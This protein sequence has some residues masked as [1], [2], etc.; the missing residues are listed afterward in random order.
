MD[1]VATSSKHAAK[2][3]GL[4]A[5]LT[6]RLVTARPRVRRRGA[7]LAVVEAVVI[8]LVPPRTAGVGATLRA[9]DA[10]RLVVLVLVPAPTELGETKTV[11]DDFCGVGTLVAS[12]SSTQQRISMHREEV[13]S[14]REAI[15]ARIAQHAA[16][17]AGR[18]AV[19][20]RARRAGLRVH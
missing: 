9:V 8:L 15:R 12:S 3:D 17:F 7:D 18:L 14:A 13:S 10:G 11:F 2:A 5:S 1:G 6:Q 19:Q 20:M 16:A 4:E